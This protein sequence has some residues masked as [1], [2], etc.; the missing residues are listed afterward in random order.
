MC[1][2]ILHMPH[3]QGKQRQDNNI[4]KEVQLLD[5][6][7]SGTQTQGQDADEHLHGLNTQVKRL[8]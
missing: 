8:C 5:L 4:S 7:Q 1:Q 6:Q 2:C 3:L